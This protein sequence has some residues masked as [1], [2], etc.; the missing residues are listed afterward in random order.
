MQTEQVDTGERG[1]EAVERAPFDLIV[2]DVNLPGID[3]FEFLQHVRR[4]RDVPV[5][6]VSGR[7]ADED[8][9]LGLGVGAA[10]TTT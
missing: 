5:I 1:L 6:I 2:L 4:T 3:G 10:R 7:N 9:I 8:M